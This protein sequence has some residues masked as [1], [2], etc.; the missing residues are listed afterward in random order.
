MASIIVIPTYNE[1]ESIAI[2]L[3]KIFNSVPDIYVM[4]VDDSSPD[5]TAAVIK[6]MRMKFPNLLLL[7]RP[8]KQGLGK[9]Y[10]AAFKKILSGEK[11]ENIIMMDG[12]LSHNPETLLPMIEQAK[13]CDLVIGSRYIKG[14][15]ITKKWNFF[16]RLLSRG[17]NIYL[18]MI[19][20]KQIKD[21]T[22]GYNLIKTNVLKRID[23]DLLSPKGYAFIFSLK[24]YLL[25]NNAQIK[26]IPIF[27]DERSNGKS[28]MT[29]NIIS[30]AILMP[31]KLIFRK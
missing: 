3:E 13:N 22:T 8:E 26:E 30:E 16:R 7:E 9:A 17:A 21:W 19:L 29:S 20:G 6:K 10:V 28:K 31:W 24:Y 25:K 1:K 23:L 5:G 2:L 4:V 15:E 11:F 14:G 27:F 12:D 18:G